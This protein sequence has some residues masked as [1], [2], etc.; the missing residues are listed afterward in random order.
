MTLC[1]PVCKR[2][3]NQSLQ[4]RIQETPPPWDSVVGGNAQYQRQP[5]CVVERLTKGLTA[6]WSPTGNGVVAAGGSEELKFLNFPVV[7]WLTKGLTAA[8]SPTGDSV[9]AAGG[10]AELNFP[11]FLNFP[12]VEWLT[13][14]LSAARSPKTH[15]DV[16]LS[17]LAKLGDV[18]ADGGSHLCPIHQWESAKRHKKAAKKTV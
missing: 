8:W 1:E 16:R 13:K 4:K 10:S 14:G 7:E 5:C 6:A 2:F 17:V 15:R 18:P 3:A 9:V 11:N 12:V